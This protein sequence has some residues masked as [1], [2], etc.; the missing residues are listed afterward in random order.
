MIDRNTKKF[1]D[2]LFAEINQTVTPEQLAKEIAAYKNEFAS[3]SG[4]GSWRVGSTGHGGSCVVRKNGEGST[5]WYDHNGGFGGDVCAAYTQIMCYDQKGAQEQACALAGISTETAYE[6]DPR[7]YISYA[8]D[9]I[10]SRGLCVDFVRKFGVGYVDDTICDTYRGIK[11]K[12]RC[13]VF[14]NAKT[15]KRKL[16][17]FALKDDG[18]WHRTSYIRQSVFGGNLEFFA[19][20]DSSFIVACEG[21]FEALSLA[22]CGFSAVASKQNPKADYTLYNNDF[23]GN[24][25]ID[26][27]DGLPSIRGAIDGFNDINAA[28]I[29]L[30]RDELKKR[31]NAAIEE[32]IKNGCC[33]YQNQ[34]F[35]TLDP[36]FA[37]PKDDFDTSS[38]D[39]FTET[40]KKVYHFVGRCNGRF[41]I[42]KDNKLLSVTA[43]QLIHHSV[44]TK[45]D[46]FLR[47]GKEASTEI[48]DMLKNAIKHDDYQYIPIMPVIPE[49][50]NTKESEAF[51]DRIQDLYSS[52]VDKAQKPSLYQYMRVVGF[53]LSGDFWTQKKYRCFLNLVSKDKSIGKTNLLA[54]RMLR[55]VG[56][57]TACI[58]QKE[59][60]NQFSNAPYCYHD[61]L[62]FDDLTEENAPRM[63]PMLT[64]VV[65]NSIMESEKKGQQNEQ[66]R[67]YKAFIIVTGNKE[68][69]LREPT[70]LTRKKKLLVSFIETRRGEKN[71]DQLVSDTI[72]YMDSH[73]G[74]ES[75]FLK[76]CLEVYKENPDISDLLCDETADEIDCKNFETFRALFKFT[77]SDRCKERY[78][79]NK[80][81]MHKVFSEAL[82]RPEIKC[83]YKNSMGKCDTERMACD[84]ANIIQ[85]IKTNSLLHISFEARSLGRQTIDGDDV[86]WWKSP[87]PVS[88]GASCGITDNDWQ[89]IQSWLEDI[90]PEKGQETFEETDI[91]DGCY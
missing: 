24:S 84:F 75:V 28:L 78:A 66:I 35:T 70:G 6:I 71:M 59:V 55:G 87:R 42:I 50:E 2:N 82:A 37:L 52:Y 91:F 12:D 10:K 49:F 74:V 8:E 33:T 90:N 60:I 48:V 3:A 68:L 73:K 36:D 65:S 67:D 76:R 85:T 19:K 1:N 31:I 9:I 57:C 47:I 15:P 29:A 27:A 54:S 22:Y 44:F 64:N 51:A 69:T 58:P 34:P 83:L 86:V 40:L 30:G 43:D 39:R 72:R 13:L 17:Q 62:I 5:V 56:L 16:M 79:P 80:L 26:S 7:D 20:S 41:V 14:W 4:D 63:I 46:K 77:P 38:V 23:A 21:E 53:V 61:V 18:V 11:V 81:L 32:H 89:C 45:K 25:F 88:A